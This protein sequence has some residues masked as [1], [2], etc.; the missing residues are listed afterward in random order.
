MLPLVIGFKIPR[1][2]FHQREAKAKP[3][4]PCTRDFSRAFNKLMVVARNSDWFIALLAPVL[5]GRSYY[6]D[7]GFSTVI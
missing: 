6:F 3:I 7:F 2:F 4:V 5:I 1:Q